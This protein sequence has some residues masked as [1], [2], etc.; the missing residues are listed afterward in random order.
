M[1][2][3]RPLEAF[4][5]RGAILRGRLHEIVPIS[6]LRFW[7][8]PCVGAL[9]ERLSTGAARAQGNLKTRPDLWLSRACLTSKKKRPLFSGLKVGRKRTAGDDGAV[10]AKQVTR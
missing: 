4:F 6:Q 9:T 5:G 8:S 10:T 7:C 2:P 3:V 1:G